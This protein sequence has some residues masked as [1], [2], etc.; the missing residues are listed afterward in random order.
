MLVNCLE[1]IVLRGVSGNYFGAFFLSSFIY[2]LLDRCH[3]A[4]RCCVA[5]LMLTGRLTGNDT[6]DRVHAQ[7]WSTP[8]TTIDL[9]LN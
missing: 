4:C 1:Q 2:Y 9:Q 6:V 5:N 3:L 8:T 7:A